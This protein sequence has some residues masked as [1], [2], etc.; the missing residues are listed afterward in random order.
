[1]LAVT[2]V[3]SMG[4]NIGKDS[5]QNGTSRSTKTG[6][7]TTIAPKTNSRRMKGTSD[8]KKSKANGSKQLHRKKSSHA[9]NKFD[10]ELKKAIEAGRKWLSHSFF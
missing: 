2:G 4:K 10:D 6:N 1:M 7:K 9:S 8:K 5:K 3:Y